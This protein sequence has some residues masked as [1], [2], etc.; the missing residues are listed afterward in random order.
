MFSFNL[1]S[2]GRYGSSP[3]RSANGQRSAQSARTAD[4]PVIRLSYYGGGHYDS[5][6]TPYHSDTVLKRSPGEVEDLHIMRTLRRQQDRVSAASTLS[7]RHAAVAAGADA[8]SVDNET[9]SQLLAEAEKLSDQ[10]ATERAA[11]DLA[12]QESRRAYLSA[13]YDDLETC[14]RM[15]L[16]QYALESGYA[17]GAMH[18]PLR[19]EGSERYLD[20]HGKAG[21]NDSVDAK[22][23]GRDPTATGDA[24]GSDVQ[25]AGDLD[26]AENGLLR[27]VQDQSERDYYENAVLSSM[28]SEGKIDDSALTERELLDLVAKQSAEEAE[29]QEREAVEAALRESAAQAG[30]SVHSTGAYMSA[31]NGAADGADPNVPRSQPKADTSLESDAKPSHR[32]H[33]VSAVS[34]MAKAAWEAPVNGPREIINLSDLKESEQMERALQASLRDQYQPHSTEPSQAKS[35]ADFPDVGFKTEEEMLNFALEAS[36]QG[37]TSHNYADYKN[38]HTG[39]SS[40]TGTNGHSSDAG[41]TGGYAVNLGAAYGGGA[42]TGAGRGAPPAAGARGG[43]YEEDEYMDEDLMRAI[44]ESLRK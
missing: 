9:E 15:S 41:V 34:E 12:L 44:A 23:G 5:L 6:V 42:N 28:Q 16:Q 14:L 37:Y 7:R 35:I 30:V 4:S 22:V 21:A 27:S 36:L 29:R 32:P 25:Y 10:E 38:A 31:A 13:D 3:P 2:A 19:K 33:D 43:G 1:F 40:Q 20:K 17:G 24:K 26:A 11:L 8:S 18:V 39:A